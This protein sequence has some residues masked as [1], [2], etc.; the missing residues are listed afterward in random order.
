[1]VLLHIRF[2]R[3]SIELGIKNSNSA[4]FDDISWDKD[5]AGDHGLMVAEDMRVPYMVIDVRD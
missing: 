4:L 1:M 3:E 5:G 2:I